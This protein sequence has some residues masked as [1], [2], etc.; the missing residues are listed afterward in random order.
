MPFDMFFVTPSS[1][2]SVYSGLRFGLPRK[3]FCTSKNDGNGLSSC[4]PGRRMRRE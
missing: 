3:T 2:A 1:Y 4:V